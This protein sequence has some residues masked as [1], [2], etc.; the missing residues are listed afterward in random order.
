MTKVCVAQGF[1]WFHLSVTFVLAFVVAYYVVRIERAKAAVA[2]MRATFHAKQH[3]AM[4]L[5]R[6]ELKD[7]DAQKVANV[8]NRS[9][10]DL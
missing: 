3:E 2:K 7:A 10:R 6:E 8:L 9:F 5:V 4:T 1:L